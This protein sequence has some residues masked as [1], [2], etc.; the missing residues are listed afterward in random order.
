ME[1]PNKIAS[2][3]VQTIEQAMAY[4]EKNEQY[5]KDIKYEKNAAR[6]QPLYSLEIMGDI[7]EVHCACGL[8]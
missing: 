3:Y 5:M 2:I 4:R 1:S 7:H 8:R 6:T